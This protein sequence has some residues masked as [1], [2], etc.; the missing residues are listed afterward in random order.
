MVFTAYTAVILM[1]MNFPIVSCYYFNVTV[2]IFVEHTD[3]GNWVNS[4]TVASPLK[5]GYLLLYLFLVQSLAG[6]YCPSYSDEINSI[7]VIDSS[8]ISSIETDRYASDN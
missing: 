6:E 7:K 4:P 8:N 3:E 5:P 2:A 1:A